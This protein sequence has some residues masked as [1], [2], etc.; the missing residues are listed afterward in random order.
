MEKDFYYEKAVLPWYEQEIL[1]RQV[2]SILRRK[3]FCGQRV[4]LPEG[5]SFMEN[6]FFSEKKALLWKALLAEKE[7]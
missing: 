5:R 4:L 3:I 6:D 7:V 1:L 2:H